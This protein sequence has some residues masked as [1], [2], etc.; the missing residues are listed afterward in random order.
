MKMRSRFVGVGLL[1][2]AV[3]TAGPALAYDA[4]DP[5]NCNG[6]DWDDKRA[7]VV[8]KVTAKPRANFIKSPYDD[9]F[10]AES[11]PADTEACRKPSYLVSGDLVLTGKTLGAFTCAVYQ[12]PLAKKQIWAKGWLPSAALAPVK[13]MSSPKTSDWLGTWSHPGGD[14]EIKKVGDGRLSIEGEMVV[15]T[16]HDVHTGEIAAKTIPAKGT[17]AFVDDGS[18]PFE[19]PDEGE[20]RV[21]MQ[22]IGPW[23]LVED[24]SGCGGA[25]VTFTGLYRRQK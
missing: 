18:T 22:R 11:C 2:S 25:A 19:K 9:D 10:K 20:C 6:V 1:L 23:L 21:R 12:S 13:P 15:P 16:A 14:I 4:Y 17:I 7:L 8:S 3:L 5:H 24:N